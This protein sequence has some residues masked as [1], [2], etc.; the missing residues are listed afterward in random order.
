[1]TL[2]RAAGVKTHHGFVVCVC[3]CGK[4]GG[5]G[6]EQ[7]KKILTMTSPCFVVLCCVGGEGEGGHSWR[8]NSP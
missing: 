2:P 1:M 5:V 7:L 6:R 4:E 3:V 8:E